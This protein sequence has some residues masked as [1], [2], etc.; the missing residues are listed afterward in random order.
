[1][2]LLMVENSTRI[3]WDLSKLLPFYTLEFGSLRFSN[4]AFI[5]FFSKIFN[6]TNVFPSVP[7]HCPILPVF[8]N[9]NI[10]GRRDEVEHSLIFGIIL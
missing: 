3:F 7:S 10:K 6:T 8:E 1:M 4:Y 9:R 2:V 5:A